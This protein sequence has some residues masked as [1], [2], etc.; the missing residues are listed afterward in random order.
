MYELYEVDGVNKEGRASFVPG[1]GNTKIDKTPLAQGTH[2]P[3][4]INQMSWNTNTGP[5]FC[6]PFP[7]KGTDFLLP[8]NLLNAV[9]TQL[10]D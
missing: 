5:I 6:P 7:Q 3:D 4:D 8:I 2:P 10:Q 9:L 1:N